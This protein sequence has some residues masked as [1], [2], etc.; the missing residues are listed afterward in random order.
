MTSLA[1]S[2]TDVVVRVSGFVKR[3]KHHLAVDGLD[4]TVNRGEIYGLIGPDGAGKSTVMKAI[5]G[6]LGYEGGS[7][8]VFGIVVDSERAAEQVAMLGRDQRPRAVRSAGQCRDRIAR[9]LGGIDFPP[10]LH[11]QCKG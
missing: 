1:P 2:S 5:A 10:R 3:Y 11:R 4:F 6:V 9:A 8:E 7:A